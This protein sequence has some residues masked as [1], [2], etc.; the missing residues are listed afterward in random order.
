MEVPTLVIGIGNEYRGDDGAGLAVVRALQAR[1]LENVRLMESDG[2]CSV[3]F[4][5]WKDAR[6]VILIDAVVSGASAG[7]ISRFDIRTESIP[8]NYALASTHAFGLA[9]TLALARVLGQLPA[10]FIVYGIEGKNFT[11]GESLSPSVRKAIGAVV[12]KVIRDVTIQNP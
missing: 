2:D 4:E 1:P 6:K 5:A 7:C 8:A 3:L 9:E 12:Q 10:S 11:S